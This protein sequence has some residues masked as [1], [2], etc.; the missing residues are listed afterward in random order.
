M[1]IVVKSLPVFVEYGS[2]I[3]V[4]W[5]VSAMYAVLTKGQYWSQSNCVNV[6]HFHVPDRLAICKLGISCEHYI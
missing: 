6:S 1:D 4:T 3:W 2:R 5:F